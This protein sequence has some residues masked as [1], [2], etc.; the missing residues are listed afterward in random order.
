MAS[1][2]AFQY[3]TLATLGR[4]LLL[5]SLVASFS[6]RLSVRSPSRSSV[7]SSPSS[8]PLSLVVGRWSLVV[9]RRSSV[10]GR[11]RRR[12]DYSHPPFLS[13]PLVLAAPASSLSP[14]TRH[15][16]LDSKSFYFARRILEFPL[17]ASA[18]NF[19][20]AAGRDATNES[21]S[22]TC[23]PRTSRCLAVNPIEPENRRLKNL[24]RREGGKR[25][26]GLRSFFAKDRSKFAPGDRTVPRSGVAR[27]SATRRINFLSTLALWPTRQRSPKNSPIPFVY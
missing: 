2:S 21:I 5:L 24:R 11:C 6:L 9:G 15:P 22:P 13:F 27:E 18:A 3:S 14:D 10:V 12:R 17:A 23:G 26:R 8:T 7:S 25:R 4:P 19:S 16:P 1:G 20:P